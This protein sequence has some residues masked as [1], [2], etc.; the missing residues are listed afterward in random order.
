MI[1]Y[2]F[3]RLLSC[4]LEDN[5][6]HKEQSQISSSWESYYSFQEQYPGSFIQLNSQ[7]GSAPKVAKDN[8]GNSIQIENHFISI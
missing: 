5:L 3:I 7:I 4:Q 2:F 6:V 8:S 1:F